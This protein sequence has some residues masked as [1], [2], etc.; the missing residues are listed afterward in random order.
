MN[1]YCARKFRIA[2]LLCRHRVGDGKISYGQKDGLV[3][4]IIANALI[5]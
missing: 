1:T 3:A 2:I 5:N 4:D